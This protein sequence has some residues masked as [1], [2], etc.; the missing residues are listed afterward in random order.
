MKKISILGS[1]GSIGTQS[2]DVIRAFPDDFQIVGLS[3]GK[4]IRL[5]CEQ[6]VEF[7]P[8]AICIGDDTQ[9][10][11]V[12]ECINNNQLDTEIYTGKDGLEQIAI[13]G[14]I[15]LLLVAIVGTASLLPTYCAINKGITIG[16][17]CKEVLVAAGSLIMNLAKEKNVSI[18]P[19]DSEHAA[20][21]QC[22]SGI[23]EDVKQ[24]DKLI[25][26]ASGGPFWNFPKEQFGQITLEDAL[27]HPNWV[28]GAKIT[29]DSATLMNKGLEVIEAHHLFDVDM[30]NI[31]VV[32]HPQ[33][34]IHSAVEFVDGTML[35]QMSMPD[36][37]FP[38]QYVLKY[39]EKC[40]NSWPKVDLAQ[41]AF[42]QFEKPDFDKFP[43]LKM[44]YD[45]G[46]KGGT[47]PVVLNAANERAVRL[48]LE[49][50][51]GFLDI[52]KVVKD[53]LNSFD[54]YQ[55]PSLADIVSIDF[56]VKTM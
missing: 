5:L 1:T 6:I 26:T 3:A 4:N 23:N 16:L 52:Q 36:M 24:I 38:I 37:R 53:S 49:K 15:D 27:K 40:A 43:L 17:A 31:D 46:T 44:A 29:I 39:P 25:L 54:H 14:G 35:A 8:K 28:M 48:F 55:Q 34:I 45:A 11:L 13:Y 22:L 21:K 32:I 30:S 56:S 47:W 2:L 10:E 9:L 33:S 20:L 50:K 12:K 51:I 7:K 42:L 19:V 41:L 18:L